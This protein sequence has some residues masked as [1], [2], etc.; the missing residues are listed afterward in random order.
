M[1]INRTRRLLNPQ[2]YQGIFPK[3]QIFWHHTAG[4]TADGAIS[5]WNQTPDRVGTAY[6]IDRDGTIYEVFDPRLWAYH[7]GVTRA[8][9]GNLNDLDEKE[10]I[11]IELVAA[12]HLYPDGLGNMVQYPLYPN[13]VAKNIIKN[14]EIW[15]MDKPWKGFSHFQSYTDEMIESLF[16]LTKKLAD[17]FKIPIQDDLTKIFEYNETVVKERTPGVWTH[18]AVRKD[19]EDV[20]P[21][22]YFLDK[23]VKAFHPAKIPKVNMKPEIKE[24]T[25]RL[26]AIKSP[27]K[28][29]KTNK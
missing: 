12:G 14:D 3:K 13:K 18:S 10:S 16:W 4:T 22:P 15:T 21:H 1:E 25:E 29:P 20:V 9:G 24:Q 6:V 28:T 5:W 23:L 7:L 26:E 17:D 2:F 11:G 27:T 19:K 8:A